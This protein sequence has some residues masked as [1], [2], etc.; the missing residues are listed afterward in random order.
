MTS[1]E[2]S[3]FSPGLRSSTFVMIQWNWKVLVSSGL[4]GHRY[5][6]GELN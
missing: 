6:S 4:K 5:A 2:S 1:E 3:E